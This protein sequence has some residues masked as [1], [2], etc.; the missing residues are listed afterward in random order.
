MKAHFIVAYIYIKRNLFIRRYAKTDESLPFTEFIPSQVV[1]YVHICP[2]LTL[3]S[4]WSQIGRNSGSSNLLIYSPHL[5]LALYLSKFATI[6]N[7]S[8]R[9]L[10]TA[11][12]IC[13]QFIKILRSSLWGKA[14]GVKRNVWGSLFHWI[15]RN[16][17]PFRCH[18]LNFLYDAML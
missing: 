5:R 11:N 18:N 14:C 17:F 13:C 1:R 9:E 12:V 10:P 4:V 6:E 8:S 16:K 15:I 3:I 2:R 7:I